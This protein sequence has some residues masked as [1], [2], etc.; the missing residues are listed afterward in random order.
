MP[1]LAHR[2]ALVRLLTFSHTLAVEVL[3]WTE[4]RCPPVLREDCLCRYCHTEVE[5]EAHVLL[6]CDGI[7]QLQSLRSQFFRKVFLIGSHSCSTSLRSASS[8][9]DIIQQLI[10]T[11]NADIL[12]SFVKYVFDILRIFQ[13]VP[14]YYFRP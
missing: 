4:R 7:D 1:V 9:F 8:G 12:C 10:N 13:C 5:D 6:D 2:K 3:R 14:V 11:D